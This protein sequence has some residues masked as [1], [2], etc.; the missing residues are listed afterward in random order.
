[1]NSE[2]DMDPFEIHL[3]TLIDKKSPYDDVR[4]TGRDQLIVM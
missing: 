3:G 4:L 2:A 1:M